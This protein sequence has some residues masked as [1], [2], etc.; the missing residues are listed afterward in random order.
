M[1]L[2]E[3]RKIVRLMI[4]ADLSE[5][6]I[7][8]AN[9]GLRLHLKRGDK[10]AAGGGPV[11]PVVQVMGGGGAPAPGAA[12]AAPGSLGAV[13]ALDD[14]LPAGTVTFDSPIVGTFYRS[15]S[16][17]ADAFVEVGTKVTE[18]S[19]LCILE[20]MKVMNEIKAEMKGEIVEVLVE[21]GEPVEFG[22]PLFL[23]KKG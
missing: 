22:Q 3:I 9:K 11:Q 1:D 8:D 19:V 16:P 6:E 15:S 18:E 17:D 5:L 4:R 14:E 20:A 21:N 10:A 12:P 23:I 2:S 13:A 7:D